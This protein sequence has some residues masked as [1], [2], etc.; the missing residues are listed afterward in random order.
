MEFRDI[1]IFLTLAEELHFG[2]TAELLHVTPGR[3][4]QVIKK[5]ERQIGGPLFERTSRN[6]RL[7]PLGRQLRDDLRPHYQGLREGMARAQ[8]VARGTGGTLTLGSMG[9]QA[10][11]LQ[12]VVELF[13]ARH[14]GAQ[15]VHRDINPVNPLAKLTS[16]EVDVAHVWL[17]VREPGLTIG[18]VTH[19]SHQVLVIAASHP[20]AQRDSICRE[21]FADLTFVAHRSPVPSY[22]EEV[23]QPFH[24][25]S[26]RPIP[27]GPLVASWDDQL[28]AVSAGQ[29]VSA[30]AAEAARFYPWP[31]L[32]YVPI[33]DAPP[34]QWAL[35][36]RA[37]DESLLIRAL[38]ELVRDLSDGAAP[39]TSE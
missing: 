30:S 14:P 12:P 20:Y 37:A 21:D 34:V 4:T 39:P 18:P 31:N 16:G 24:T 11:M 19:T 36:W 22:M 3:V 38:V 5:Q 9:P 1:E 6:V 32:V 10:W 7:T 35:V 26:G 13:Q 27:R 23:F 17:P 33:P 28:K 25:P 15:L 8:Q 29:A 2:R